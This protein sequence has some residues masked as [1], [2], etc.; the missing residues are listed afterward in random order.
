MGKRTAPTRKHCFYDFDT[1]IFDAFGVC[2]QTFSA[3][4]FYIDF[5]R[6]SGR[7]LAPVWHPFYRFSCFFVDVF[8]DEFSMYF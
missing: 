2:V 3:L 1:S 5:D 4:D 6:H 8:F 7:I